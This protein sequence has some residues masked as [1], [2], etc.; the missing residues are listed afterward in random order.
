MKLARAVRAF[1]QA[2]REDH[3]TV[4]HYADKYGGSEVASLPADLVN[5]IG[6]QLMS[7]Y[8]LMRFLRDAGV[9]LAPKVVS[10]IIRHA[11]GADIHWD[12]AMDPGVLVV[13]GMGMCISH[14]ASVGPGV[15]LFQNVT[16]GL[17]T[18]P[19]TRATGAPRIER[20]VHIGP[21]ATII[22]PV[23]IGE[24]SKIMAGCT[25]TESIPPFSLVEAPSPEI[26]PRV[27]ARAAARVKDEP[28]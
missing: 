15:I 21:G 23:T 18:H 7:A 12:A 10:R 9:P 28:S 2:V 11:Y 6:F 27:V 3:A 5:K 4:R 16:L 17:G 22:G 19:E 26:R 8:R 14:A 25:V 13:H 1:V 20:N 24:G